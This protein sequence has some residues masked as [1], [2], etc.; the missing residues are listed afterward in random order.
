MIFPHSNSLKTFSHFLHDPNNMNKQPH[1]RQYKIARFFYNL[2]EKSK[3]NN[4]FK[5][6]LA[7]LFT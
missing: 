7:F 1:K 6:K 5:S 3:L 4:E 2:E